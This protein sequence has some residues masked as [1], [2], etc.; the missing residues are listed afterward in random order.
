LPGEGPDNR[1]GDLVEP[2][3]LDA[4]RSSTFEHLGEVVGDLYPA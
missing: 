2:A 3:S 4:V 1:R